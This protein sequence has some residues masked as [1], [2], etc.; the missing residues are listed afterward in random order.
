MDEKIKILLDKISYSEDKYSCFSHAKLSKIVVNKNKST[1]IIYI[2]NDEYFP[3]FVIEE[4]EEKIHMLDQNTDN[5]TIGLCGKWGS[6]KTSI[7]NLIVEEIQ[8]ITKGKDDDEKIIV[9]NFNPWNYS[10]RN[11]V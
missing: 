3:L 1:W 9:V 11:Q 2:E 6:G 8:E 7:I 10:D 4:L 5:F